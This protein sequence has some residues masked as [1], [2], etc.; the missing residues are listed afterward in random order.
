M[1]L[2][3]TVMSMPLVTF[4]TLHA[5]PK[6]DK[7]PTRMIFAWLLYFLS[8][9]LIFDFLCVC[10]FFFFSP[11]SISPP[12]D[13]SRTPWFPFVFRHCLSL[14]PPD[15]HL[16]F[17]S[18]SLGLDFWL[19]F[20]LFILTHSRVGRK[21]AR[22]AVVKMGSPASVAG[23]SERM[24]NL[25]ATRFKQS[26]CFFLSFSFSFFSSCN[27]PFRFLFIIFVYPLSPPFFLFFSSLCD[28]GVD[29]MPET[30]PL[31]LEPAENISNEIRF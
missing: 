20:I 16:P 27:L 22:L 17:V 26:F 21:D 24:N 14:S 6:P 2:I 9:G 13:A 12:F 23:E 11:S 4:D 31:S 1:T 15:A 30:I 7:L 29:D 25:L 3:S 18:Q 5:R 28:D 19:V 10:V 8:L